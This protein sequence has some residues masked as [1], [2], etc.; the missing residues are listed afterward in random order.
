MSYQVIRSQIADFT[1]CFKLT[2]FSVLVHK[3]IWG[4][5]ST[6]IGKFSNAEVNIP[7]RTFNTNHVAMIQLCSSK[8]TSMIGNVAS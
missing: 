1:L 7:N 3:F 8:H 4:E 6:G 2:C 5:I